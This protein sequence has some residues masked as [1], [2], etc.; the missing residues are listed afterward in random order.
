MCSTN[1]RPVASA[2]SPAISPSDVFSVSSS[3]DATRSR[4][5]VKAA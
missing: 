3:S 5:Q 1:E 2:K 4:H